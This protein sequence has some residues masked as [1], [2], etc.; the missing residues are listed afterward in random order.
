[1]LQCCWFEQDC[2]WTRM[3]PRP[4]DTR[5]FGK[6]VVHKI[7]YGR[8]EHYLGWA[9]GG[10]IPPEALNCSMYKYLA[11]DAVDVRGYPS[12]AATWACVAR[13]Q[14]AYINLELQLA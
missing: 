6:Q 7:W 14:P 4:C 3:N 8:K 2:L 1:M 9:K 5:T 12:S 13:T 10:R 11:I